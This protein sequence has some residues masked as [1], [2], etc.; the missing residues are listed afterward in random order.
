VEQLTRIPSFACTISAN[1]AFTVNTTGNGIIV[2]SLDIGGTAFSVELALRD[3]T[4]MVFDG[5]EVVCGAYDGSGNITYNDCRI[6]TFGTPSGTANNFIAGY[7]SVSMTLGTGPA[8]GTARSYV[9]QK[10]FTLQGAILTVGMCGLNIA[11]MAVFDSAGSAI[12]F[13]S[14]TSAGFTGGTSLWGSGN[15]LYSIDITNPGTIIR[16]LASTLFPIVSATGDIRV[17]N[18]T[19]VRPFDDTAGAYAATVAL[20]FANLAGATPGGFGNHLISPVFGSGMAAN[21]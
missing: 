12:I 10:D 16:F 7:S 21:T 1:D 2:E 11:D 9:L 15:A 18:V 20:S 6:K 3:N 4:N 8:S 19:T 14:P 17:C 5:C 13:T